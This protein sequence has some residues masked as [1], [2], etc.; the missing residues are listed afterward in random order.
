MK[1]ISGLLLSVL[2]SSAAWAGPF[3]SEGPGPVGDILTCENLANNSSFVIRHMAVV[4][5]FQ[6]LYI[7][8]GVDPVKVNM[9]CRENEQAQEWTCSE[10][11]RLGGEN[12]LYAKAYRNSQGLITAQ[13][14][15]NNVAGHSVSEDSLGCRAGE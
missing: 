5:S 1:T 7:R 12:V 9:S 8:N 11:T 13:L 4:T 6:G 15:R 10:I 14:F 3:V 2:L